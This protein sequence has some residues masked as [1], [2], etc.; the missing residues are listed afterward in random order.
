MPNCFRAIL[1]VCL[2]ACCASFL[3]AAPITT[4]Q[5]VE[6]YGS[7]SYQITSID[8]VWQYTLIGSG[9]TGADSVSFNIQTSHT[10]W[11][12][13]YYVPSSYSSA[14]VLQTGTV[15]GWINI[16][17]VESTIFAF[18]FGGGGGRLWLYDDESNLIAE[19]GV[20][21]FWSPRSHYY[22]PIPGNPSEVTIQ[23]AFTGT[24]YEPIP[25]PSTWAL[26]GVGLLGLALWRRPQR[27]IASQSSEN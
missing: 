3:S 24:P 22:G 1:C 2:L 14:D 7:G 20:L 4:A 21:L 18:S 8:N 27:P 12:A 15:S 5:P 26:A 13:P 19:S 23:G 6:I 25:E 11:L 10:A 16:N 17:G 9:S